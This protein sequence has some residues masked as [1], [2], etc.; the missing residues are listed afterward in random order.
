MV[1]ILIAFSMNNVTYQ[2]LKIKVCQYPNIA[3][4]LLFLFIY[5]NFKLQFLQDPLPPKEAR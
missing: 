4:F 1:H 2:I 5:L 3:F